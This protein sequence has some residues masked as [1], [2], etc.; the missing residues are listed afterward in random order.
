VRASG[1]TLRQRRAREDSMM[2]WRSIFAVVPHHLE[3]GE[4]VWLERIERRAI[5]FGGIGGDAPVWIYRL[6]SGREA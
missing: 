5:G 3:S 6:S 1:E 4:W 2:T